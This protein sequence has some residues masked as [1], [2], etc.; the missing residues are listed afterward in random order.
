MRHALW[1]KFIAVALCAAALLVAVGGGL[2]LFV[3]AHEDLLGEQT[4]EEAVAETTDLML[5]RQAEQLASNWASVEYGGMPEDAAEILRDVTLWSWLDEDGYAYTILDEKRKPLYSSGNIADAEQE[6]EYTFQNLEYEEFLALGYDEELLKEGG[7]FGY[8]YYGNDTH[9]GV[10]YTARNAT[11]ET[12]ITVKL[13]L[14]PGAIQPSQLEAFLGEMSRYEGILF[15]A[16]FGGLLV[17]AICAVYLC[18]AAGCRKGTSEIKAGG[19]NAL[20]LDM[21]AGGV[22]LAV[23]LCVEILDELDISRLERQSF[24]ALLQLGG[25][26]GYVCCLAFVGF[27][28]AFA[29]QVKMKDGHWFWNSVTG[30]CVK[31]CLWLVKKGWA[32]CLLVVPRLWQKGKGLAL[33][34]WKFAAAVCVAVWGLVRRVFTELLPWLWKQGKRLLKDLWKFASAL[35]IL[36]WDIIKK[37][38]A[39]LRRWL[40]QFGRYCERLF[41]RLP[42]IWQWLLVGAVLALWLLVAVGE[43]MESMVI[44]WC[45]C[46]LAVVL[47]GANCFGALLEGA[48]R[49]RSGDLESKVDDKYLIG[50][51]REFAEELNGL[52]DV[53]MVAAQKQL[54]SDRMKTELITNVSHDIKTPLTSIINYVDLLE[55]PHTEE[56]EKAYLEVL[57]RQSQRMKKLI[58]D[59]M[60]MSKASTGNIQVEIGKIDAVEAVNQALGEFADKLTAAGL[61]PV[62]HQGSEEVFLLADGRLLWRAM[63]NV[64][65]NAVKY[66]LPG[67]RLYVD[68]GAVEDKAVISFKN[69]SGAQLNISA[70]ELMERF[71]RG[72]SSRNTEG[73][74][75][76]LNIA[77]S[78]MELQKGQLQLLVDGDLFKVTLVFP[79]SE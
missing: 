46:A 37:T 72:D 47:Y 15:A 64:L 62:F 13:S 1:L 6:L 78:L 54:K 56:Q 68:V 38:F 14:A 18:A 55:K 31:L 73:S 41:S 5:P 36:G 8:R 35:A 17:F 34:L 61:T 69:I 3:L 4:Y 66:A 2:G 60:E 29:A 23:I 43:R 49:M 59:L 24:F 25:V 30:R 48:K 28:F 74:G 45:F 9:G 33:S 27:C 75:L 19:L 63:S 20:P 50:S 65:S 21:Y 39:L 11:L 58:E 32:V 71:V 79:K 12:P 26:M 44:L 70:E 76:G 22:L 53:A 52:A 16:L 40:G 7:V 57:S 42:L 10:S 77:K 67:T 51:F